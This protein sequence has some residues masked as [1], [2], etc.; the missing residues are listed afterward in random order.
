MHV[1]K[2][3]LHQLLVASTAYVIRETGTFFP[4]SLATVS[5]LAV[6]AKPS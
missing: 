6:F 3:L 4:L 1:G 2:M 5:L